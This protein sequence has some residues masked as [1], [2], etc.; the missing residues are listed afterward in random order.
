M[1]QT[2]S[3]SFFQLRACPEVWQYS[4]CELIKERKAADVLLQQRMAEQ[5][6]TDI[7]FAALY[8]KQTG[9]FIGEAG[10]LS[11]RWS[12]DRCEVGYNLLPEY[13]GRGYATEV[14]QALLGYAFHTMHMERVEA[15]AMADNIASCRVLE[16]SGLRREGVLRHFT[17][18]DGRYLDVD[19]YGIIRED[20]TI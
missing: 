11:V 4:T 17:K 18:L 13:W 3:G 10:I 2:K 19:Y 16:K 6:N 8:E 5:V 20:R 15:L 7:G 1:W 12:V 9:I 14:T